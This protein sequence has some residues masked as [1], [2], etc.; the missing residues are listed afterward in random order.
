[1]RW[2][3]FAVL[4][5][6]TALLQPAVS[7]LIEIT[8]LDARPDFLLI[9]MVYFAVNAEGADA[10]IA[11]FALGLAADIAMGMPGPRMLAF[12]ICGTALNSMRRYILLNRKLHVFIVVLITALVAGLIA[13]ALGLFRVRES[14]RAI[15]LR[16]P[17]SALY[18]AILAPYVFSGMDLL[19]GVLGLRGRRGR[20]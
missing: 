6:I 9:I 15:L 16:T 4:V 12:G 3:Q 18:S 13:D 20:T 10:I 14:V 17:S 11:S 1:M 7:Q 8:R 2:I 19:A 5:I